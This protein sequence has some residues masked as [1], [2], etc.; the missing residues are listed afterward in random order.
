[1]GLSQIDF[2]RRLFS[3]SPSSLDKATIQAKK[4]KL[5][6]TRK[7]DEFLILRFSQGQC[8]AT[9]AAG[10]LA[11]PGTTVFAIPREMK[12]GILIHKDRR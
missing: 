7:A 10:V 12:V 5:S 11:F 3:F 9:S 1:M 4:R 6:H 2:L 8:P